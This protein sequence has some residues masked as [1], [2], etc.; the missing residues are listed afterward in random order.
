M[1]TA[2]TSSSALQKEKIFDNDSSQTT[3]RGLTSLGKHFLLL[4]LPFLLPGVG[5]N[6]ISSRSLRDYAQMELSALPTGF[7][8]FK[9]PTDPLEPY[10]GDLKQYDL[11]DLVLSSEAPTISLKDYL[12]WL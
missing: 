3:H 5:V 1:F 7:E 6:T 8:Y 2:T 11:D 10:Y 9:R 12:K 4:S